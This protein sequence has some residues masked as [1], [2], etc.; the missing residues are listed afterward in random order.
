MKLC[1]SDIHVCNWPLFY[2]TAIK[3][4]AADDVSTEGTTVPNLPDTFS[5]S[6]TSAS[7]SNAKKP[8]VTVLPSSLSRAPVVVTATQVHFDHRMLS[9]DHGN[10]GE[11]EGSTET[12][13]QDETS[14]EAPAEKN[15]NEE[16]HSGK[17]EETHAGQ[18]ERQSRYHRYH[19]ENDHA[20]PAESEEPK[21][22]ESNY[23]SHMIDNKEAQEPSTEYYK[24][25]EIDGGDSYSDFLEDNELLGEQLPTPMALITPNGEG[26]NPPLEDDFAEAFKKVNGKGKRRRFRGGRRGRMKIKKVPDAN[27]SSTSSSMVSEHEESSTLP[28]SKTDQSS[29]H[30]TTTSPKFK[31]Y[32]S[33]TPAPQVVRVQASTISTMAES[34]NDNEAGGNAPIIRHGPKPMILQHSNNNHNDNDVSSHTVVTAVPH[35]DKPGNGGHTEKISTYFFSTPSPSSRIR[36]RQKIRESLPS[37]EPPMSST[38]TESS[39]DSILREFPS[40]NDEMANVWKNEFSEFPP[41]PFFSDTSSSSSTF[42]IPDFVPMN[43]GLETDDHQDPPVE[44]ALP[45]PD[46]AEN[47]VYST[48]NYPHQTH[49]AEVSSHDGYE[50]PYSSTTPKSHKVRRP[51]RVRGSPPTSSPEKEKH[52]VTEYYSPGPDSESSS[53]YSSQRPASGSHY[54]RTKDHVV[55]YNDSPYSTQHSPIAALNGRDFTPSAL[56]TT[57]ETTSKTV[58]SHLSVTDSGL[59][60]YDRPGP[61]SASMTVDHHYDPNLVQDHSPP[62]MYTRGH[63]YPSDAMNSQI[64]STFLQNGPPDSSHIHSP[65]IVEHAHALPPPEVLGHEPHDLQSLHHHHAAPHPGAQHHDAGALSEQTHL[66][67]AHAHH[68]HPPMGRPGVGDALYGTVEEVPAH[69][70]TLHFDERHNPQYP[71]HH[72]HMHPPPPGAGSAP[73]HFGAGPHPLHSPAMPFHIP[74][75]H[76]GEHTLDT[77]PFPPHP[78]P[79]PPPSSQFHSHENDD[80][81]NSIAPG[82]HMNAPDFD[83]NHFNI[84]HGS[85]HLAGS[86]PEMRHPHGMSTPPHHGSM[87]PPDGHASGTSS[88]PTSQSLPEYPSTSNSDGRSPSDSGASEP[89]SIFSSGAAPPPQ[90]P[91]HMD[92]SFSP[93]SHT[94]AS[95]AD[96]EPANPPLPHDHP[97]HQNFFSFPSQDMH[98]HHITDTNSISGGSPSVSDGSY[99]PGIVESVP[100]GRPP[101]FEPSA[102][103]PEKFTP[104][105]DDVK[106]TD[107]YATFAN[108]PF[109]GEQLP[110]EQSRPDGSESPVSSNQISDIHHPNEPPS[111]YHGPPDGDESSSFHSHLPQQHIPPREVSGYS[112]P[113]NEIHAGPYHPVL[114]H[115]PSPHN[116]GPPTYHDHPSHDPHSGYHSVSSHD[117]QTHGGPL[118]GPPFSDIDLSPHHGPPSSD[119]DITEDNEYLPHSPIKG[120]SGKKEKK[121]P[122]ASFSNTPYVLMF[123]QLIPE[124]KMRPSPP[125][126]LTKEIPVIQASSLMDYESADKPPMAPG[127][128]AV[129]VHPRHQMY[130]VLAKTHYEKMMERYKESKKKPPS[131]IYT[132]YG[133]KNHTLNSNTSELFSVFIWKFITQESWCQLE[134]M[135]TQEQRQSV[136]TYLPNLEHHPSSAERKI[137]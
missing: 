22:E 37:T 125:P 16:S 131:A 109:E 24:E 90:P 20:E 100:T 96:Y 72:P 123:P 2:L 134:L 135:L 57:P 26:N 30:S 114:S 46:P 108:K 137:C 106:E 75:P 45:R 67:E 1:K 69:G 121:K 124:E 136:I 9:V 29:L 12:P 97:F 82:F 49:S 128:K 60:F 87:P 63:V 130:Q 81:H 99:H 36:L 120:G 51:S 56:D 103:I 39:V 40:E 21:T 95:H 25:P 77:H 93:H 117:F 42:K 92:Q 84:H 115:G 113:V 43:I 34:P 14:T 4:E 23:E 118:S 17:H 8:T 71:H 52:P 54:D 107:L 32:R 104:I 83:P 41:N 64:E 85:D 80:I 19:D 70:N 5:S 122:Q 58:G 133:K 79:Q 88:S 53:S 50:A 38:T 28:G 105:P 55:F 73:Y 10:D 65:N 98:E 66:E 78:L 7:L 119:H 132:P 35:V 15:E 48:S 33:T 101:S 91:P 110:H 102:L 6:E 112:G 76:H 127:F 62:E 61:L 59:G 111:M 44:N 13:V 18:S 31:R 74:P 89:V 27:D 47:K 94:M 126:V 116:A 86:P 11:T 3:T 68:H 129:P